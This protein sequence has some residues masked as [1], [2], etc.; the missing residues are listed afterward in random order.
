MVEKARNCIILIIFI[1]SCDYERPV[2]LR[3]FVFN[4]DFV[5]N[6][7]VERLSNTSRPSKAILTLVKRGDEVT[8]DLELALHRYRDSYITDSLVLPQAYYSL[9]KLIVLNDQ[10][11]LLYAAPLEDSFYGQR[12]DQPLPF[13]VKLNE[14][15]SNI[16]LTALR[17]GEESDLSDFGYED[18]SYTNKSKEEFMVTAFE[19]A[20]GVLNPTRAELQVK[21]L[22]YSSREN[23]EEV[24][25]VAKGD[26][27]MRLK[28]AENYVFVFSSPGFDNDTLIVQADESNQVVGI[29]ESPIIYGFTNG[30]FETG[31]FCG[32]TLTERELCSDTF[33]FGPYAGSWYTL[34]AGEYPL[35]EGTFMIPVFDHLDQVATTICKQEA[36]II[37]PTDG[38]YIGGYGVLYCAESSMH[39]IF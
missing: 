29:F 10:N 13:L 16:K 17:I 9:T 14:N 7:K 6:T 38:D 37:E 34:T 24:F 31:D 36:L 28:H 35:L 3:S 11:E 4:I 30:S 22:D 25:T 19:R 39:Q 32:W 5:H 26:N 23:W 20:N 15:I 2:V 1:C 27:L 21:G 33:V 8:T 18:V 12:F